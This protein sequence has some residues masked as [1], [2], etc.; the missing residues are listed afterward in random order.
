MGTISFDAENK[1]LVKTYIEGLNLVAPKDYLDLL[2]P[3][4]PVEK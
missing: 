3:T 2:E 4:D 1:R